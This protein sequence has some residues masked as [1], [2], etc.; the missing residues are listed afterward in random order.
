MRRV[1]RADWSRRWWGI[2]AVGLQHRPRPLG[3]AATACWRGIC[4]LAGRAQS[5]CV[6][7]GRPARRFTQ[8]FYGSS[9]PRALYGRQRSWKWVEVISNGRPGAYLAIDTTCVSALRR[10]VASVSRSLSLR[11]HGTS[12]RRSCSMFNVWGSAE[13]RVRHVFFSFFFQH[14]LCRRSK[15]CPKTPPLGNGKEGS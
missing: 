12:G 5:A 9:H 7:A 4:P 10:S 2:L 3:V 11:T 14:A 8:P 1:V 13:P 6:S 15:S